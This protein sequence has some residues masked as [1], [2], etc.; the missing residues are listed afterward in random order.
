[1]V[2]LV[3]KGKGNVTVLSEEVTKGILNS[4]DTLAHAALSLTSISDNENTYISGIDYQLTAGKVDWSL[5]TAASLTGTE[6]V[7]ATTGTF[8]FGTGQTFKITIDGGTEQIVPATVLIGNLT[9]LATATAIND[10]TTGLTASVYTDGGLDYIKIV[11]D[12][13]NNSSIKIGDGTANQIL[14]F[15]TYATVYGSKEPAPS[16]TYFVTYERAK[17][18]EEYVPTYFFN[19]ADVIDAYGEPN[20]TNTLSLGAEILFKQNASIVLCTQIRPDITPESQAFMYAVDQLKTKTCNIVVALTEDSTVRNYVKAHVIAM[21]NFIE[22]KWRTA[23]HGLNSD[24]ANTTLDSI[25]SIAVGLNSSRNVLIYPT[26]ATYPIQNVGDTVVAGYYVA[27]AFA[28]IAANKDYDVSEPLLRKE[29]VGF[30]QIPDSLIRAEKNFLASYGICIIETPTEASLVRHPLTTSQSGKAEDQEYNVVEVI[31][32]VAESSAQLLEAIYVGTKI[33]SATP[34]LV[35]TT[36]TVY[37]RTLKTATTIADFANV[38]AS[39]N[40]LEPRQ[41]DVKFSIK[42]SWPL[43]W[44]YITFSLSA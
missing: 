24:P 37:L 38:T 13:T 20:L 1:M 42:P 18:T 17:L 39:Q 8:A 2:A 3:G 30:T 25:K 44:I 31:D 33:I 10:N 19:L 4:Q 36:T 6:G 29:V 23:I 43:N 7:T 16:S 41:I 27:V 34:A 5:A 28:G 21:S 11:S 12:S 32:F 22:R 35:K 40:T 26:Q 9:A 14:G 15:G